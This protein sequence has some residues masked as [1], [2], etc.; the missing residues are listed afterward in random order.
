MDKNRLKA[1]EQIND[2]LE[3]IITDSE[4]EVI[5]EYKQTL[6]QL[7]SELAQIF[8]DYGDISL[9]NMNKYNRMDKFDKKIEEIANEL[10]KINKTITTRTLV[11]SYTDSFNK[12]E[13]MLYVEGQEKIKA[14][15]KAFDVGKSVNAEMAGLKWADRMEKKRTDFIYELKAELKGGMQR[16]D[17]YA[18]MAG[19]LDDVVY[20]L[21][22]GKLSGDVVNTM[23]IVR[24]EATRV[25]SVGQTD[26]LDSAMDQG[27]DMTKEW[28]SVRDERVRSD[29]RSMNGKTVDYNKDFI[30]P[31]GDK[32]KAPHQTGIA[33]HDINCR[34]FMTYELK[35]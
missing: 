12:N 5:R 30:L 10:Y 26:V 9:E 15:S 28:N 2:E 14:I 22:D 16:G 6:K 1:F 13:L 8:E 20:K 19:R 33:K 11:K 4:K 23:R 3:A 35:E 25:I 32:G 27:L 21:S 17:S 29:H 31:G 7:K 34:C 24:T 18:T